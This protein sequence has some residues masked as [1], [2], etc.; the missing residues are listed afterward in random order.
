M[1]EIVEELQA[2]GHVTET[3]YS[4]AVVNSIEKINQDEIF[5]VADYHETGGTDG[6]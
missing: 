4:A 3:S 2:K 1:Q 6:F 5:A